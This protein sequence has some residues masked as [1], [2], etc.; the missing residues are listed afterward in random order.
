MWATKAY[1]ESGIL[2]FLLSEIAYIESE[3]QVF[4]PRKLVDLPALACEN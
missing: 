3:F 1:Y 2:H 4:S